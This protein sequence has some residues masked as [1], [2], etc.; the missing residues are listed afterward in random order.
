MHKHGLVSV[1]VAG[2]IGALAFVATS[3]RALPKVS[4]PASTNLLDVGIGVADL[5]IVNKVARLEW[6]FEAL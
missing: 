3:Q 5:G 6:I 2:V 4:A 1:V